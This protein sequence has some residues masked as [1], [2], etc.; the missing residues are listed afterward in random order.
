MNRASSLL[1]QRAVSEAPRCMR[2][3]EDASVLRR[4]TL[5]PVAAPGGTTPHIR[6]GRFAMGLRRLSLAFLGLLFAVECRAENWPQSNSNA[7][8]VKV[9]GAKLVASESS[10]NAIRMVPIPGAVVPASAEYCTL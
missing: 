2:A 1:A 9:S 3:V 4:E 7:G 5:H 8:R 10:K 6:L